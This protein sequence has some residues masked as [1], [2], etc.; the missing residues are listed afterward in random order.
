MRSKGNCD[1][2]TADNSCEYR[3]ASAVETSPANMS[4]RVMSK[5]SGLFTLFGKTFLANS[6][7]A[8][9]R[10]IFLCQLTVNGKFPFGFF[11]LAS[12]T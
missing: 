11:L 2:G 12:S 9:V 7:R 10:R 4:R 1:A 6:L 8:A 5:P 3:P